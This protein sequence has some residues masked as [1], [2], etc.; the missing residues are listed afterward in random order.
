MVIGDIFAT[1]SLLNL[2]VIQ[3]LRFI[4]PCGLLAAKS[5]PV[6]DDWVHEV[7]FDGY[8]VQAHK[9]GSNLRL[10]SRNG[11]DVAEQRGLEGGVSKRRDAP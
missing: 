2:H 10:Y 6:G 3:T 4:R 9:E 1:C 11:H 8:R 5:V 7:K